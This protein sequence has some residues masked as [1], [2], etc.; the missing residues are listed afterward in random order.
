MDV[1]KSAR[2]LEALLVSTPIERSV[3]ED[4]IIANRILADQQVLDAY[5]D[6]SIRHPRNPERF[7]MGR[8]LPPLLVT[9]DDIVEYDLAANAFGARPEF[10]H[11]TERFL[12]SEIYRMRPDVNAVVH[13]HSSAV[14]PFANTNIALRP[15]V[16][17]TAFLSPDV[18]IFEIRQAAKAKTNL[19][20]A[21]DRLGRSV[22]ETLG[23]NAV[24][25]LRGHGA[26]I[27]ASSLSLAVFRAIYTDINARMQM[28]AMA[29]GEP[30]TFLNLDEAMEANKLLDNIH[31]R[32]WH[33]WKWRLQHQSVTS[34]SAVTHS[35]S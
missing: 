24:A 2:V 4:L 35:G 33:L 8:V 21:D 14:I 11:C 26:V 32:A 16:H 30:I 1:F 9:E 29:T 31:R 15:M 6:I 18:P 23:H 28:H 25:L 17:L 3:I 22:A 34:D 19:L 12:H 27:V 13:S 5:G 7:L 20:V 10:D